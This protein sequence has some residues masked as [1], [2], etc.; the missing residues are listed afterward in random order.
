[1]THRIRPIAIVEENSDDLFLL[2]HRLKATGT[3]L[4][5]IDFNTAAATI[6]HLESALRE[7]DETT[8][9]C[10]LFTD[11]QLLG[12]D[13]FHVLEWARQQRGLDS[14]KIYVISGSENPKHRARAAELGAAGYLLKMPSTETL[15]EILRASA[16]DG[17]A[18]GATP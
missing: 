1:M 2:T 14:L 5:I 15:S 7:S 3:P 11:L 18:P 17:S 6:A 8:V 16:C 10:V 4:P 13:G 12:D 9:P